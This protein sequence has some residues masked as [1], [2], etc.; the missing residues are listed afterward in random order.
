MLV[1]G[2]SRKGQI[3]AFRKLMYPIQVSRTKILVCSVKTQLPGYLDVAF[4]L[5]FPKQH[6][7]ECV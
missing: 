6:V 7:K 3:K 2:Q 5:Q 4:M 1:S